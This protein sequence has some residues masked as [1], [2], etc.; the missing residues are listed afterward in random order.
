MPRTNGLRQITDPL[1]S[2]R[3]ITYQ[4]VSTTINANNTR[5]IHLSSEELTNQPDSVSKF[6]YHL[7]T[8][9]LYRQNQTVCGS[10]RSS[11]TSMIYHQSIILLYSKRNLLQRFINLIYTT[12]T[13]QPD[14]VSMLQPTNCTAKN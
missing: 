10:L 9:Q 8:F 1:L 3:P 5:F 4:T 2:A 13:N 14:T 7:S 6:V 12:I 11:A